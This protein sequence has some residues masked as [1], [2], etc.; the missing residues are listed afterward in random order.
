MRK[1][2]KFRIQIRG[3]QYTV[4]ARSWDSTA[5]RLNPF[6]NCIQIGQREIAFNAMKRLNEEEVEKFIQEDSYFQY[7]LAKDRQ[8]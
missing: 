4:R 1:E 2:L 6:G 8:K 7:V 3:K 5:D